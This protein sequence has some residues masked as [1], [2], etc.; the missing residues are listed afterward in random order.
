[1]EGRPVIETPT[2]AEFSKVISEAIAPAFILGALS[3]LMSVLSIRLNRVVDRHRQLES[4]V[5]S[6]STKSSHQVELSNLKRRATLLLDA[7]Y[8]AIGGSL[9]TIVLLIVSFVT[10]YLDLLHS[11]GTAILFSLALGLFGAALI[12]FGREVRMGVRDP[13]NLV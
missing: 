13:K 12:N 2:I 11:F 8:W 9:A 1:V 7:I 6:D 4:S 3:G 10:A 5:E